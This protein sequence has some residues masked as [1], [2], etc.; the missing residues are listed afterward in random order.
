MEPTELLSPDRAAAVGGGGAPARIVLLLNANANG[1]RAARLRRPIQNWLAAHHR[2]AMLFVSHEPRLARQ[3]VDAL[4]AGS[5][6]IVIGGD[7]SVSQLLP[8]LCTGRH[9]LGLVPVGTG[10]DTAAALGLG[11]AGWRGALAHALQ[12]HASAIDLGEVRWTNA[13][14]FEQQALFISS[15]CTGFDAA[16]ARHAS[17]LPRWLAGQPRYLIATLLELMALRAF[18]LRTVIDGRAIHAGP[19]LLAS[20]LNTRTYG[21]GMPIAPKAC[22]DDG[23]LDLMLA[24]SM[25]LASVLRLLPRMLAGR[26][27]GQPGVLHLRFREMNLRSDAPVPVAADGEVLG[28]ALAVSVRVRPGALAVVRAAGAANR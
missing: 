18:D 15:L 28:D 1:G 7:G 16:V 26:H 17:E 5:R 2:R 22:I 6:V 12:G 21:G 25:G 20:S 13:R 11:R 14:G 10:N 27:L 23:Q 24:D 3:L 8:S 9:Q 4:P 19:V